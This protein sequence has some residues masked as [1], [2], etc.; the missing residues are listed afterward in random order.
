MGSLGLQDSDKGH[1]LAP[2]QRRIPSL[3]SLPN[4]VVLVQKQVEENSHCLGLSGI[5]SFIPSFIP[6]H[7]LFP[8]FLGFLCLIFI[9]S[10]YLCVHECG[11][12]CAH[13]VHVEV[14]GVWSLLGSR[15][16][17]RS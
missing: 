6:P 12:P 9:I 5:H 10:T 15:D 14:A 4:W 11:H 3:L 13:T 7:F 1:D 17:L 8:I 2:S 16:L